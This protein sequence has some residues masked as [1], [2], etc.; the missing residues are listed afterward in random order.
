MKDDIC[1]HT[2]RGLDGLAEYIANEGY[3]V[4]ADAG[5][6]IVRVPGFD[7]PL[8]YTCP[9]APAG[10]IFL[11]YMKEF[12][13]EM[14]FRFRCD[15]C[16]YL[17]QENRRAPD[18]AFEGLE[19]KDGK[20]IIRG[21]KEL[22][23]LYDFRAVEGSDITGEDKNYFLIQFKILDKHEPD[24]VIDPARKKIEKIVRIAKEVVT[25]YKYKDFDFLEMDDSWKTSN[26]GS[27]A[28]TSSISKKTM[29]RVP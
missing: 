1:A 18:K 15:Y 12:T 13:V 19:E 10:T 20:I 28:R 17:N 8:G 2:H 22:L 21:D 24:G 16:G 23:E 11:N 14:T 3:Y 25:A 9:G 6:K 5:H 29:K 26:C 27:P 4:D 7:E